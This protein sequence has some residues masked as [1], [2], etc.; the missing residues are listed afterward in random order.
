MLHERNAP[1]SYTGKFYFILLL[2]N[3]YTEIEASVKGALRSNFNS[4]III[5]QNKI[6]FL[7]FEDGFKVLLIHPKIFAFRFSAICSNSVIFL[8]KF[9]I[10]H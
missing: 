2:K 9:L 4:F 7:I 3:L 8:N 10:N 6:I 5:T 1:G